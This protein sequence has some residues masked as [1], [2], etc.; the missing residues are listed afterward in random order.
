M[1]LHVGVLG[2][3][4][5]ARAHLAALATCPHVDRVMLAGRNPVTREA[6]AAQF[7]IVTHTV[8]DHR[9]VL[10][11]PSVDVVDIVLPHDLHSS[12]SCEALAAGKHVICE[13]PGA[14]SLADF[15]CSLAAAKKSGRHF[16]VVMNQLYNGI[17]QRL[18]DEVERG[19]I[20]R[21]FLSVENSFTRA[22]K[23]Y[24]DQDDWRN[25][26]HLAGGGVLI[27]GGF[28]M[29]YR[30]LFTLE[31]YGPPAWVMADVQQLHVRED[32]SHEPLKGED[33]V[34]ITVGYHRPLRIEWAH[35]WTLAAVPQRARQSFLAGT[36]GTLELTDNAETPL[37]LHQ[38]Q[39]TTPLS[40]L[41]GSPVDREGT[42]AACLHDYL[43]ALAEGEPA[44]HSPLQAR[45]ALQVI[46]AAYESSRHGLRVPLVE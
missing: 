41:P 7:P 13:K 44:P 10:D 19:S 8:D 29:V 26:P 32:Q 15:D 36:L 23:S 12:R 17:F 40:P 16:L 38:A 37:V 33:F 21:P 42:L 1:G 28:H 43:K 18:R 14:T 46:L 31:S 39:K 45:Q 3:G 2:T 35:A 11:D 25:T 34:N 20:G 5:W 22:V 4:N 24:H 30:H 27:D 6:L 9:E